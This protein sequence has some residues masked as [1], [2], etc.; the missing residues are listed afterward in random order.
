MGSAHRHPMEAHSMNQFWERAGT[1]LGRFL[2]AL[3]FVASGF[4]KAFAFQR[5][6]DQVKDTMVQA[7]IPEGAVPA[8][9][10]ITIAFEIVGGLLIM[11]GFHTRF[12]AVLV[13][14]FLLIVTPIFHRFW[15]FKP[16]DP[17]YQDQLN[18][19]MKNVSILGAMLLLL[20][21]GGGLCSIDNVRCA[22]PPSTA[23]T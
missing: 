23:A 13:I 10:V 16:D 18:N 5:T 22:K 6:V 7:G 14:G 21:R 9:L 17:Q 20:A 4:G 15:A 19:F 12:G 3:I 1:V 2:L 8:L 11:A